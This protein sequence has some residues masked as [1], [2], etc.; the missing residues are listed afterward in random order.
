MHYSYIAH[1]CYIILILQMIRILQMIHISQMIYILYT[2][3]ISST[4]L[5]SFLRFTYILHGIFIYFH[6]LLR[7]IFFHHSGNNMFDSFP[8]WRSFQISLEADFRFSFYWSAIS[9][10][11]FCSAES[12]KRGLR[13]WKWYLWYMC[14]KPYIFGSC[15]FLIFAVDV[16]GSE[17]LKVRFLAVTYLSRDCTTKPSIWNPEQL[18][19]DITILS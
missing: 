7:P 3:H 9:D 6:N 8:D 10:R 18:S 15:L 17:V 4:I 12:P 16:V 13:R 19:W 1:D 2:I 14:I 11:R 5:I